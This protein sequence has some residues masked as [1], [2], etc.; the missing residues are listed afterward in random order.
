[1]PPRVSVV[2]PTY[3]RAGVL[4][5]AVRSVL[6]QSAPDLELIVVDDGS[7]DDTPRVLADF[8]DPLAVKYPMRTTT[9]VTCL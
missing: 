9:C 7:T 5:R 8:D 4:G 1:M 3:N 2:L 6:A